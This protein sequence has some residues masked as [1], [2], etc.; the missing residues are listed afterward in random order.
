MRGAL[1]LAALAGVGL[2]LWRVITWLASPAA[3]ED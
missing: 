1:M 2:L 3:K